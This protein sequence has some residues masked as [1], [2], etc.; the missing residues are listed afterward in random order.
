M[1]V[2]GVDGLGLGVIEPDVENKDIIVDEL[3][4]INV[5]TVDD[6]AAMGL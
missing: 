1:G 6:L 5:N 4:E 2:I 3:V